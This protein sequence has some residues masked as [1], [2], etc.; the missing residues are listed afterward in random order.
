MWS[1]SAGARSSLRASHAVTARC[2]AYLA[3]GAVVSDVPISGGSVTADA[4]SQVRRTASVTIADPRFWPSPMGLDVLSPINGAELFLE[5]GI[6]VPG[7]GV[8][9]VPLFTGPVQKLSASYPAV[10]AVS[11][12]LADRSKT[13]ADD[14]MDVPTQTR[15]GYTCVEEITRLITESLPD[16][17]VIDQTNDT[18]PAPVLDIDKE[19]WSDGVEKLADAIGAECFAD[20]LG[21]FIIRYQPLI[22]DFPVWVVDSGDQGVLVKAD[23]ELTREQV[24]NAVVASGERTDGTPAVWAKVVDDNPGSPTYYGGPFGKK[25]RYYSSPLLTT[26]EQATSA[27]EAL[28]ARVRGYAASVTVEAVPNPALEPGDVIEVRL[29]DGTRTPHIVDKVPVALDV[30]G[31]QSLATRTDELPAEGA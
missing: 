8:E 14:R 5:R 17:E 13:V 9:W 28:L 23:L 3:N 21:R 19:R 2:T 16:A 7:K 27:A 1:L 25:V 11:V 6:V 20:Q 12:E 15:A 26:V 4:K 10:D 31:T 22:S 30:S 18:T 24:Y 29:P